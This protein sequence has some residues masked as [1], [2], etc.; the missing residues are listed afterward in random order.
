MIRLPIRTRLTLL[1]GALAATL[2]LLTGGL[3]FVRFRTDVTRMVHE[4]L[5]AQA[6]ELRAAASAGDLSAGARLIGSTGSFVQVVLRD[7][8]ILISSPG[9]IDRPFVDPAAALRLRTPTTARET[10]PTREGEIEADLYLLPTQAGTI[11]VGSDVADT[12]ESLNRLALLLGLGGAGLLLV[13][14]GLAWMLAGAALRP[15]ERMRAEAASIPA[16]ER[17]R[18]L[19]V[20]DTRDEVERLG[21]TLNELLGRLEDAFERERRFVDDASHELRTPLANLRTELELALRRS[22]TPEELE[23]ALR[24]AAEE[25]ERLGRLAEDLLVLARLD[26]LPL[27]RERV[28]LAALVSDV[29]AAFAPR[30]ESAGV[31]VVAEVADGCEVEADGDRLRQALGNLLDNALRYG[32]GEVRIGAT[33]S[34]RDVAVAVE[35]QGEGFPEGFLDHAFEPFARPDAGRGQKGGGAGLGLAIVHAVAEAHGG[36][37]HAENTSA[38]AVVRLVLPKAEADLSTNR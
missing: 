25:S 34:E 7:G 10:V 24:S 5:R 1:F 26:R 16:R 19:S 38:G 4:R 30:A 13:T 35:D 27:R 12:R 37:A 20:P 22:R 15:I 21:A 18:R 36:S 23:G 31:R 11:V 29:A 28:D 6:N 17:G 3:L 33:A 9:T 32:A 8:T 14:T 2:I